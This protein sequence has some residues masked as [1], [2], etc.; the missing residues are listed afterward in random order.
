MFQQIKS[1][2]MTLRNISETDNKVDGL[3]ILAL[4]LSFHIYLLFCVYRAWTRSVESD[5]NDDLEPSG[6]PCPPFSIRDVVVQS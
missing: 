6:Q 3:N 1:R 4:N 5:Q 2:Y